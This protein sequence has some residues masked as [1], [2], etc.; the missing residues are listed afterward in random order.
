MEADTSRKQNPSP[1]WR[2]IEAEIQNPSPKWRLIEIQNPSPKWRWIYKEKN[3]SPKWR[4]IQAK[5]KIPKM[6]SRDPHLLFSPLSC[7]SDL[8]Q[9]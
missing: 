1:K 7:V 8:N 3:P 2:Q 6:C 5:V 9:I 4:R